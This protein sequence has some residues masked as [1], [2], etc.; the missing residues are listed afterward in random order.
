MRSSRIASQQWAHGGIAAGGAAAR[1]ASFIAV[2]LK[3][4]V[5]RFFGNFARIKSFLR[6]SLCPSRHLSPD[7]CCVAQP[8]LF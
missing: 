3:V 7:K 5:R 2:S 8:E 6:I 4:F 1:R